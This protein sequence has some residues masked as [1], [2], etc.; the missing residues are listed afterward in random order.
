METPIQR[1]TTRL[2]ALF[3]A[4]GVA[5]LL[6]GLSV[7]VGADRA[8]SAPLRIIVLGKDA[9]AP[10]PDCP[11]KFQKT[12]GGDVTLAPC[13][14]EGHITGFQISANGVNL[15]VRAP[16]E[17]KLVS[18]SISLGKPSRRSTENNPDS[19]GIYQVNEFSFFNQLLDSP[20]EARIA[21]LRKVERANVKTFKMVRQSPVE[22]LN[23]YFGTTPQFVLDHPLTVLKDQIVALTIP[24]WAPMFASDEPSTSQWRGSR[25]KGSCSYPSGANV[26]FDDL[27]AFAENSHPQQKV[28]SEKQYTCAYK[29]ARLLYTA[30]L[31]KKPGG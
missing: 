11:G 27:R 17:G 2:R 9:Q 23:P 15:P 28:G 21:V 5:C 26:S 29:G 30:T 22:V 7:A 13:L 31:I 24:T 8:D 3:A 14:A 12:A 25:K 18:W 1:K 4:L 10:H 16:F 20:A 19:K 6:G